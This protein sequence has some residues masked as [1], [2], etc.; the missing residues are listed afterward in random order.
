[1]TIKSSSAA[2]SSLI[3]DGFTSDLP[4]AIPILISL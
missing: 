3:K 2:T 1:V 4:P